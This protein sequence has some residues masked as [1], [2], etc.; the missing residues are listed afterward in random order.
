MP[1]GRSWRGPHP[2]DRDCFSDQ[3]LPRVRTAVADLSWLLERGY[4]AR[5]ALDLVGNRYALRDRQRMALQRCAAGEEECRRRRSNR[6]EEHALA[7]EIIVVDGY[8]VLLTIEAALSG[9]ALLLARD[10]T[11]RDL[12]AMSAHYRRVETTRPA[13]ELLAEFFTAAACAEVRWYLDSPVSNSD[14]LRRLIE[15]AV[16]GSS[17]PW[18][19]RLV[20]KVDRELAASKHIVA[21]ADS[22]ILD[23][24]DRWFN[25][26]RRIVS[27]SIPTGWIVDLS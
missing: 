3:Q 9:G 25:L 14:R 18:D 6:V 4:S 19:V 5:A 15:D 7:G 24:C 20:E 10:G 17:P 11:V 23:R 12:A 13:I 2:K 8:N 21:T 16:T 27:R 26:A 22:R 1:D